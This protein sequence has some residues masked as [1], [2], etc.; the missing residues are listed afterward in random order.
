MHKSSEERRATKIKDFFRSSLANK[1]QKAL[2]VSA[3]LEGPAK[4]ASSEGQREPG[5]RALFA[6]QGQGFSESSQGS[7]ASGLFSLVDNLRF[8]E[9]WREERGPREEGGSATEGQVKE[10]IY[11]M[12]DYEL[13]HIHRISLKMNDVSDLIKI[14]GETLGQQDEVTMQSGAPDCSLRLRRANQNEHRQSQHRA[15]PG[16]RVQLCLRQVLGHLFLR[17]GNDSSSL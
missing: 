12:R 8:E 16:E 14:F 11:K 9:S 10:L 17:A 5:R 7:N 3:D 15:F 1:K 6:S 4:G 13:D 2:S